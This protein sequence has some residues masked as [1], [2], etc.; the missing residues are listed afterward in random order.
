MDSIL[1][2]NGVALEAVK[3][4]HTDPAKR[5]QNGP[6]LS[7]RAL[8]IVHLAMYDA[9][10]GIIGGLGFPRY[11]SPAPAPAGTSVADAVAG[12]AYGTL[13]K[14]YKTQ[15]EFFD[16]QLSC[17]EPANPS[18]TFGVTVADTLLSLRENDL[19][20]R[21]CGYRFSKNRG[22]HRVDPD[23]PDQGFD[24]PF[25]GAQNRG[26]AISTRHTVGAPPLPTEPIPNIFR[27]FR[28]FAQKALS[29]S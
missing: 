22:R 25:Y 11:L 7:S 23:N 14:L 26:F 1:F 17:F 19:D 16:A 3:V 2:W 28:R 12:A 9:Y 29:P 6:T 24:S 4:S 8:A 10:A 5:E 18:F 21:S 15:I 20:A 13:S 27:P